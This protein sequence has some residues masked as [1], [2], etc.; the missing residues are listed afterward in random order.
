MLV[1]LQEVREANIE[2]GSKREGVRVLHRGGRG[3]PPSHPLPME[4][5]QNEMA[6]LEARLK[7]AN[8][9]PEANKVSHGVPV[10]L[11]E[12]ITNKLTVQ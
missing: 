1:V 3:L 5:G 9:P 7:A 10:G 2:E 11:A 12:I 8:L 4:K 6:E